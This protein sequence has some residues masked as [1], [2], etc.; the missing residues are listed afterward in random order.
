MLV[1]WKLSVAVLQ[2]SSANI[3]M[4]GILQ[5][6]ASKLIVYFIIVSFTVVILTILNLHLGMQIA[7]LKVYAYRYTYMQFVLQYI[8]KLYYRLSNFQDRSLSY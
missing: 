1:V 7:Y 6:K 4:V 3:M 2:P 5:L 8:L